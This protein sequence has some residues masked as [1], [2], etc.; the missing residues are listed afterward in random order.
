VV[1]NGTV[2][3]VEVF[4]GTDN[5]LRRGGELAGKDGGAVAVKVAKEK[6]DMRFDIPCLGPRTMEVC[7]EARI[8]ALGFE[9]GKTLLLE[10]EELEGIVKKNKIGLAAL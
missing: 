4:E 1:K 5:C 3:A 7:R 8:A 10:R 9:G 6:H 2:L